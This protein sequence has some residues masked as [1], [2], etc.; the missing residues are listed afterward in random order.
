M[1]TVSDLMKSHK[2]IRTDA[3]AKQEE[4]VQARYEAVNIYTRDDVLEALLWAREILTQ[5]EGAGHEFNVCSHCGDCHQVVCSFAKPEWGGDHG[6]RPMDT[7]S[8]A[9]VM[10]VCEYMEGM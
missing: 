2:R 9:V 10:A 4:R 6:G 1:P 7:G 5:K 3:K 8:E